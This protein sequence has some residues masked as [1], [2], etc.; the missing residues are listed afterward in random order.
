MNVKKLVL[1]SSGP[2]DQ[3]YADGIMKVRL[4]RLNEDERAE[5]ESLS[6]KLKDGTDEDQ[7]K[8]MLRF[9]ELMSKADAYDPVPHN[10]QK[11]EVNYEIHQK[12]WVQADELRRSGQL[13]E[14]G[15]KIK[16]PVVAIHGDYDSHS[17]E[18][19]KVPLTNIIKNF[20]F[21][22]IP[23]CGHRPWQERQA[24]NR[25]YDIL[26]KELK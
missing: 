26:K 11:I 17:G 21:I 7:N 24:Q 20:R 5:V 15:Q 2:F 1:V 25:F 13:M 12:V 3:K 19:V 22:S 9:G 23:K 18:G 14:I 6:A 4:E 16:C 8:V 10:N